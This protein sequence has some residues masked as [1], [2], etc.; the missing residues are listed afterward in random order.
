[1]S[2]YL[3]VIMIISAVLLLVFMIRRIRQS[4][5]K[6]Q[7]SIF[8]IAFSSILVCMGVFP[9]LFYFLSELL[10]FQAPINMIYIVIIFVLI[11]KLFLLSIQISYLE[12]KVDSLVQWIAIDKKLD[13]EEDRDVCIGS[14]DNKPGKTA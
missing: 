13:E 10:G 1:M 8:W 6:I 3:R 5:L 12:N 7:Y 14:Q 9:K 2:V 4:R 11:V